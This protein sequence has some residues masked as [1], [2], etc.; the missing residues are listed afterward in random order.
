[1]TIDIKNFYLNTPMA[2]YEYMRL[3]LADM[4]EDVI[5]HYKLRELATPDGAIYCEIRKGMYGL[6]QAGIIAQELL[7]ERLSKH[8]YHQSKKTPGLWTHDTRPISFSLVVDDFGVKYTNKADAD[9]LL[10]TLEKH[11]TAVA[12]DWTG[13]LYCGI[14]LKWD[15]TDRT[16]DISMP[17][18]VEA[19]LVKYKHECTKKTH[20]P[21]KPA[22]RKFGK[23]AQDPLP[24][25]T[26]P[27][28]DDKGINR[29]QQIVGSIL[30]YARAVDLT[31]LP[32]L[33]TL[34]SEQTTATETTMANAKGML[35]YLATHPNATIRYRASDMILN[36][37]SDAS[38]L[39]ESRARS[40]AAGY[41]R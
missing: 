24:E 9:H 28:L 38:Y 18:Y 19:L 25:D 11:Y 3:R 41:S 1:M 8:G 13:G 26:S 4:P 33:N 17:G 35:D 30:F 23:E 32:G 6:P 5:E 12:T 34:A 7:K 36:V 27:A 14:T 40:R 39:S 15:Y 37:H 21:Y 2:R 29:I 20:T 16:L 22:P 31:N 10:Q